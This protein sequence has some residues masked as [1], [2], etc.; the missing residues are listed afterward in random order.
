MGPTILGILKL[1][2]LGI[3]LGAK[4]ITTFTRQQDGTISAE[5][6]FVHND[7]KVDAAIKEG[8]AFL[9]SLP[10]HV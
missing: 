6:T 7:I 3:P 1:L 10:P 8:Q 2:E 5:T 4:I 9:A